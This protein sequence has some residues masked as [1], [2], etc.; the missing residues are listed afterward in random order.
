MPPEVFRLLGL[1]MSQQRDY[2]LILLATDGTVIGWL[3]GA[4]AMLGYTAQE[5]VGRPASVFFVQE[6]LDKGIDQYELEVAARDSRSED[7]R[8]HVRRDGSR[9]WVSGTVTALR[10]EAGVLQGF[11]KVVRDRTDLRIKHEAEATQLRLTREAIARTQEFLGT[12][13]H[14]MRNPLAPIKNSVFILDRMGQQLAEPPPQL[15]SISR[16][17][18]NQVARLEQLANDMV[19]VSRLQ[20][21]KLQLD[22]QHLD[23]CNLLREEVAAQRHPAGEKGVDLQVVLPPEAIDAVADRARLQQAVANLVTNAIKYTPAGG[24]VWVKATQEADE[25]VIRIEDTGIGIS[26]DVLP[27]IFELFTQERR[28]QEMVPGGLGIG[29]GIVRQV[30]ELHGGVVQA[31]SAGPGKGSEFSL[32]LRKRGDQGVGSAAG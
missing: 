19:E 4:E 24:K 16:I 31:R 20:H 3:C 9:I 32:R 13:G 25:V 26:P 6:D 14:E 11:I 28:A 8:W 7:D 1:A 2:G 30:M 15:Q 21:K 23:V 5:I 18:T 10:D 17:L 22:L 29:L 27:R 12:L